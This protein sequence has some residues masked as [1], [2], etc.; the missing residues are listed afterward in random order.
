M[1]RNVPAMSILLERSIMFEL[2]ASIT[3]PTKI[4][5]GSTAIVV[6]SM[7]MTHDCKL[8]GFVHTHELFDYFSFFCPNFCFVFTYVSNYSSEQALLGG[9]VFRIPLFVFVRITFGG[10]F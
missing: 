6:Y 10:R 9:D 3:Y 2:I 4:S 5:Y 7:N 1:R 8:N